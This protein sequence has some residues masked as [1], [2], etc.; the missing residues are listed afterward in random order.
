MII[1]KYLCALLCG[2]RFQAY[3]L[4]FKPL[5]DLFDWWERAI[6]SLASSFL[7]EQQAEQDDKATKKG[8]KPTGFIF[9]VA[10][11]WH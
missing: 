1:M 6:G 9:L 3:E 4:S 2:A 10:Y 5:C 7:A 11:Y 8:K